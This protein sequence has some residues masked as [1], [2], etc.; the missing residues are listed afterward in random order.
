VTRSLIALSLS[1]LVSIVPV[2]ARGENLK[3]ELRTGF[4]PVAQDY[5][6]QHGVWFPDTDAEYLLHL[7][8]ETAP[9]LIDTVNKQDAEIKIQADQIV[10]LTKTVNLNVQLSTEYKSLSNDLDK[11][12]KSC[13][14]EK[15]GFFRNPPVLVGIGV[16]SGILLSVALVY[17][18]KQAVK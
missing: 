18:V 13:Q 10:S 4:N 1:V 8:T 17:G 2:Y 11:Q 7:R 6:G 3:L 15:N 9:L 14:D 12:L 5:K 16:V